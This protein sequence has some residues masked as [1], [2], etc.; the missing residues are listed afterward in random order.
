MRFCAPKHA[1]P[2]FEQRSESSLAVGD[3]ILQGQRRVARHELRNQSFVVF[4][5][6]EHELVL[7]QLQQVGSVVE[8]AVAVFRERV[9]AQETREA[10][11]AVLDDFGEQAVAHR[12]LAL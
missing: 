9:E 11:A 12:E 6:H 7:E 5:A 2:L 4:G 1:P 3:Q 10:F 8:H